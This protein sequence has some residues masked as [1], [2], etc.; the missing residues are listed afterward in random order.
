MI[1]YRKS[2]IFAKSSYHFEIKYKKHNVG[3]FHLLV[4]KA[5]S[6]AATIMPTICYIGKNHNQDKIWKQD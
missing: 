6:V 3:L 4:C 5:F 2:V 1:I